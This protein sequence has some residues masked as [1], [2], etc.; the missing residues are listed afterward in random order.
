[1]RRAKLIEVEILGAG[2]MNETENQK[3]AREAMYDLVDNNW[4]HERK[5]NLQVILD[6]IEKA[7]RM[8]LYQSLVDERASASEPQEW[9]KFGEAGIDVGHKLLPLCHDTES[10][11]LL[12]DAHN[13]ALAAERAASVEY[14]AG[15]LD[16]HRLW[17]EA[18]KDLAMAQEKL[19]GE[20]EKVKK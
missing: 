20:R 1:M 11:D 6:A 15:M 10:R 3:L 5:H 2:A 9:T 13:A 7:Y 19:A 14:K 12:F 17:Q 16:N 18:V 8:G 4:P